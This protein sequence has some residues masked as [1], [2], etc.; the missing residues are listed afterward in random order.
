MS[1]VWLITG[2]SRGFGRSLAEA[3]LVSMPLRSRPS[4][5][6]TIRRC[7]TLSE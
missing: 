2:S 1:K 6:Q 3:V 7:S 5:P 4:R